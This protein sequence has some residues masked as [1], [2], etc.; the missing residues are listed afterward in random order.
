MIFTDYGMVVETWVQPNLPPGSERPR[1]SSLITVSLRGGKLIPEPGQVLEVISQPALELSKRY[2]LF[3][4]LIP[5]TSSYRLSFAPFVIEASGPT[6][7][8]ERL[9]HRMPEALAGGKKSMAA[10]VTDLR[11]VAAGCRK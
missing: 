5:D 11:K 9:V 7:Q 6:I 2:V 1:S 3:L 10:F 8:T 4:K